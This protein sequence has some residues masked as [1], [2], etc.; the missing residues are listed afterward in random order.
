MPRLDCARTYITH[1]SRRSCDGAMRRRDHHHHLSENPPACRRRLSDCRTDRRSQRPDSSARR[2]CAHSHAF[3]ARRDPPDVRAGAR[4]QRAQTDSPRP[5]LGLYHG[6]AG[7]LHD[8]A[9]LRMRPRAWMDAA[10]EHLHRRDS[11]HLEHDHRRKGL[12]GD[13]CFRPAARTGVRRPP[14]RRSHCGCRACN[15]D[16]ARLGRERPHRR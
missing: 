14:R 4:V 13:S 2:S 3:R 12:P 5:D 11:F 15:F 1:I 16:H 8:L 10:R 7:R 6:A 9:R